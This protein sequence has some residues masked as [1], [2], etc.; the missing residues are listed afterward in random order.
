MV[1]YIYLCMI[2]TLLQLYQCN[3][4]VNMAAVKNANSL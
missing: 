4:N 1:V 3:R 2:A